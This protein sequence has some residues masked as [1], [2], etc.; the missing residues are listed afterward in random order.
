MF[1]PVKATGKQHT[2]LVIECAIIRRN[3]LNITVFF[4]VFLRLRGFKNI[5][6]IVARFML[7]HY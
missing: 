4:Q 6:N 3:S 5:A 1:A 2:T 7:D